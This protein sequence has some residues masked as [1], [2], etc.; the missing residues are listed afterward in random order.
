MRIATFCSAVAVLLSGAITLA[1]NTTY[2]FDRTTDF[3]R[4][5]TYAWVR[6]T[7]LPDEFNH[8]RVVNAVSTQLAAKG[9]SQVGEGANPDLFVAYHATFGRNLRITGFSTGFGP[10]G[11]GPNRTG[12]AQ[13]E[14]IV[15]GTLIVD[16]VNAATRNIVWRGIASKE[17]D[18]KADPRKRERNINKAAERL[19][20][21][22]PPAR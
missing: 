3:S 4:F 11:F 13:T 8:T 18:V 2:D 1:Q 9:L 22:Y 12:S 21:N 14:E 10:Y 6:G 5:R 7:V 17:V 19:F 16:I 20:K 15:N